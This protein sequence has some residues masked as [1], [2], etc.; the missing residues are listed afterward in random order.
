MYLRPL[1]V[2][3]GLLP[4]HQIHA[5]TAGKPLQLYFS[6]VPEGQVPSALHQVLKQRRNQ[7][8]AAVSLVGD[9]GGQDN[10]PA[11][12]VAFFPAA[13]PGSSRVVRETKKTQKRY[14][15][16]ADYERRSSPATWLSAIRIH[17]GRCTL[18]LGVRPSGPATR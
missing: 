18:V 11:E 16:A 5:V 15:Y 2:V 13:L 4:I 9:A 14:D 10:I 6:F 1:G 3:P 7:N 12:K 8:L 17:S